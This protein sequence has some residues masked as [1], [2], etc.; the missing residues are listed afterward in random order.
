MNE[1]TA[2]GSTT[3]ASQLS[4]GTFFDNWEFWVTFISLQL[5]GCIVTIAMSRRNAQAAELGR[6]SAV[7]SRFEEALEQL[8]GTK[9]VEYQAELRK[10]LLLRLATALGESLLLMTT[11]TRKDASVPN[12]PERAFHLGLEVN[13]CR[14]AALPSTITAT[15]NFMEAF[16]RSWQPLWERESRLRSQK[17]VAERE[18][19]T[20][21]RDVIAATIDLDELLCIAQ[22][23]IRD[24]LGFKGRVQF[25]EVLDGNRERIRTYFV[26]ADTAEGKN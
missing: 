20:L 19:E 17:V 22:A 21:R 11:I 16:A 14:I 25:L 24:D 9:A 15:S 3:L 7:A 4:H 12:F 10:E 23:A 1:E 26:Q 18:I 5:L 13:V 6:L 2:V 8:S